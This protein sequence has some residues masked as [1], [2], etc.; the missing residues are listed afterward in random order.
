[1]KITIDWDAA[2]RAADQLVLAYEIGDAIS[3]HAEDI[4]ELQA[5]ALTIT[6]IVTAY[7]LINLGINEKVAWKEFLG[8]FRATERVMKRLGENARLGEVITEMSLS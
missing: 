3:A 7:G 1:M 8:V 4:V 2:S 6:Q 5:A